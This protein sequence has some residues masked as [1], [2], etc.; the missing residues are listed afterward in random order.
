MDFPCWISFIQI[1]RPHALSRGTYW[2]AN[3]E[4]AHAVSFSQPI[5][6]MLTQ[7]RILST[8]QDTLSQP[9]AIPGSGLGFSQ[10]EIF[11]KNNIFH[12]TSSTLLPAATPSSL[13]KCFQFNNT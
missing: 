2:W 6:E 11:S 7:A 5:R 12:S 4:N 3:Q 10:N 9:G 1:S 8:N 13:N